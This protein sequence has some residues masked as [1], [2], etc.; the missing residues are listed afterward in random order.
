ML[1]SWFYL[2]MSQSTRNS[3][4]RCK[5][6]R[7]LR[8]GCFGGGTTAIITTYKLS[9][10][11]A[12]IFQTCSNPSQLHE[13]LIFFV[14]SHLPASLVLS[15]EVFVCLAGRRGH[16]SHKHPHGRIN[17]PKHPHHRPHL[18]GHQSLCMSV[19][20]CGVGRSRLKSKIQK[21]CFHI[22]VSNFVIA[23]I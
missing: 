22:I 4:M 13:G 1:I 19:W 14:W 8:P 16:L 9:Q 5:F 23:C 20:K 18:P 17:L 3:F 7:A 21:K 15:L 6:I 12:L 11:I 10:Q 2:L